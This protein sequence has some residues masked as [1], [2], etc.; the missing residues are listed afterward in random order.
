MTGTFSPLF[1]LR[2]A[3]RTDNGNH[4]SADA[5]LLHFT[6]KTESQVFDGAD[7]GVWRLDVRENDTAM[8][9]NGHDD[10]PT[11]RE[12]TLNLSQSWR[13]V[14]IPDTVGHAM[15][16]GGLTLH[17]MRAFFDVVAR[18]QSRMRAAGIEV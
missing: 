9:D 13:E 17:E 11:S 12:F 7:V 6:A 2:R 18:V 5:L 1:D 14:D 4:A 16:C 15:E 10:S 8:A 3:H